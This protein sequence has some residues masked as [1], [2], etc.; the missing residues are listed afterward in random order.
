MRKIYNAFKEEIF[1]IIEEKNMF[2]VMNNTKWKE[3]QSGVDKLKFPPPYV[4]KEVTDKSEKEF[5]YDVTWLGDWSDEVLTPF[6]KIEYIKVRPR[7]LK[8]QGM[9]ADPLVIDETMEF[10][11]ILKKFNIPYEEEEGTYII[12][13]YRCP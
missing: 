3:L 5:F 2:S 9:L 8:H 10:V 6:F 12:Y 13:G 7:C 4:M 11:R 1:E